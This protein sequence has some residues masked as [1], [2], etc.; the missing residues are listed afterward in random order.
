M[1]TDQQARKHEGISFLLIDMRTPGVSVR[2]IET[3]DRGKEI[4]EV[5]LENVEV[6]VENR[7]GKEG[8]GWTYAKFLL[9]HE[10]IPAPPESRVA[11]NSSSR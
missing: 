9:E 11:A 4:N 3:I 7:I 10:R 5:N 1:R 8:A 6:P 2:P